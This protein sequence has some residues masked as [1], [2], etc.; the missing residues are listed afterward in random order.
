MPVSNALSAPS[1]PVRTV[2][3]INNG[4]TTQPI[5]GNRSLAPA[6][7]QVTSSHVDAPNTTD[8]ILES[9]FDTSRNFGE[10]DAVL[11]RQILVAWDNWEKPTGNELPAFPEH[12]DEDGG[13]SKNA[14]TLLKNAGFLNRRLEMTDAAYDAILMHEIE[15]A[16]GP[17][18]AG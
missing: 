1:I 17:A 2:D 13:L 9:G 11:V 15:H 3:Q 4:V 6:I 12:I 14:Q 5:N 10:A 8:S 7:A 18:R 16:P